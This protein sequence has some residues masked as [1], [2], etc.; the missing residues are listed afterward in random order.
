MVIGLFPEWFAPRP[1]DWPSNFHHTSSPLWDESDVQSN[2]PELEEFLSDGD[3]SW[4]FTAGSVNMHAHE[5]FRAAV[6]AC[7]RAGRRGILIARFAEQIPASLPPNVR[8]FECVPFS[9]VLPRAAAFA[10]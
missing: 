10:H 3:R 9:Q 1:A 8:P 5:F 4:V 6:E 7:E 2:L